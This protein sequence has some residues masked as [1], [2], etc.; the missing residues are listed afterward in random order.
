MVLRLVLGE[1]VVIVV[2]AYAPHIGLGDQEKREFWDLLDAVV[3][4]I[5][6]GERICIG[7]DFNGYIGRANDGFQAVHGGFGFGNRNETGTELLEFAM[8][9]D[10]DIGFRIK[11]TVRQRKCALRIRWGNLKDEKLPL[12]K[13][14]LMLETLAQLNGD[15]TQ[16]WESMA[17]KIIQVAKET[18]GAT[19]GNT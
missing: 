4:G 19:T 18:L 15:S 3:G 8:A 11:L 1:E 13:D 17:T 2:C 6:R 10:L 12:F 9:H 14:K 7:G 5:P 16:I